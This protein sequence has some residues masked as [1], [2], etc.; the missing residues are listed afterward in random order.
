MVQSQPGQAVLE[1]LSWKNPTQKKTGRVSQGVGPEFKLAYHKKKKK[2]SLQ[3]TVLFRSKDFNICLFILLSIYFP[4]IVSIY[5]LFAALYKSS[6]FTSS[7]PTLGIITISIFLLLK[8]H[9]SCI[10]GD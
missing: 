2:D 10:F 7:S 3:D 5:T 1:T 4:D 9:L 6:S 8:K